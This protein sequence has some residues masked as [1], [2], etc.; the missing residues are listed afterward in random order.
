VLS[1]SRYDELGG[2]HGALA[3][4]A[5]GALAAACAA[6]GRSREEVLA[7]LLR[8]V[9][10]DDAGQASRRRAAGG[11]MKTGASSQI[12]GA[13]AV[14]EQAVAFRLGGLDALAQPALVNGAVGLVVSR[15]GR[16][17]TVFGFTV[18]GA[19]IVE[20]DLL[21]DPERLRKLDLAVLD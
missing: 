1:A 4:Q 13:L 17:L 14:A 16:P 5:D 12:R 2:V 18:S 21:A 6:N 3:A 11:N 15:G 8:L 19:K 10:V 7:G 20:I 9:T